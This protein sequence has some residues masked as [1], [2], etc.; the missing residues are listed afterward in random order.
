[1]ALKQRIIIIWASFWTSKH[2]VAASG[3]ATLAAMAVF[4]DWITWAAAGAG[5]VAYGLKRPEGRKTESLA[6]GI[7]SIGFGGLGGPYAVSVV[8]SQGNPQPSVYLCSF[9][10][11][12]A[13]PYVWDKFAK[14]SKK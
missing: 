5:A 13:A 9:V 12:I 4:D 7:A 10:L 1:M 8:T 3:G 2:A 14:G 11:A 6:Y